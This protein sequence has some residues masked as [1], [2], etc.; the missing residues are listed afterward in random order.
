MNDLSPS[1][2][3]YVYSDNVYLR[4]AVKE[5]AEYV[6]TLQETTFSIVRTSRST[7]RKNTHP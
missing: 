1:S 5:L 7:G 4:K 3:D 6:K 2:V